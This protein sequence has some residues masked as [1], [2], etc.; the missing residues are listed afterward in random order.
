MGEIVLPKIVAFN[1]ECSVLAIVYRGRSIFLWDLEESYSMGRLLRNSAVETGSSRGDCSRK[2]SMNATCEAIIFNSCTNLLAAVYQ[3]R[4][5]CTF[6]TDTKELEAKI[7]AEATA[8]AC[9]PDG[10]TLACGELNGSIQ[11]R[12]FT[13]LELHYKIST[14]DD[15]IVSLAFSADGLRFL[16]VRG[17]FCN[18]WE[19]S[20]LIR[21]DMEEDKSVVISEAIFEPAKTVESKDSE[22]IVQITALASMGNGDHVFVG[23]EQGVITLYDTRKAQKKQILYKHALYATIMLLEWH[24]ERGVLVSSDT[25]NRFIV[26][27][28]N[29]VLPNQWSCGQ[30]FD[31]RM[32]ETNGL[33]QLVLAPLADRF[34]VSSWPVN[35]VWS[36][37]G[38]LIHSFE[39]KKQPHQWINHPRKRDELVSIGQSTTQL[40]SW[41]SLQKITELG[42]SK[43]L[44]DLTSTATVKRVLVC[45]KAQHIIISLENMENKRRYTRLIVTR[46]SSLETKPENSVVLEELTGLETKVEYLIGA[47]DTK[48]VFLDRSLWVCSIDITTF[49]R[50]PHYSRHFFIPWDWMSTSGDPVLEINAYKDLIF[51]KKDEIAIVKR[52]FARVAEFVW[53]NKS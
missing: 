6:N 37:T 35:T 40:F 8:L 21:S 13:T 18:V 31:H 33:K 25:S 51:A 27:E 15:A 42:N 46:F 9:S 14:W 47:F 1:Q 48:V 53:L 22:E 3:D 10:Q 16:D 44:E 39:E 49:Q 12:N 36:L 30:L 50:N 23:D 4:E 20:I 28:I 11:L 19:P 17:S 34:L 52:G 24:Q 26:S 41:R 32:E 2:R 43:V 29:A 38:E 7:D 45:P 5:I